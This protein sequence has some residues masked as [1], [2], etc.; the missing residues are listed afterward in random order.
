L[1]EIRNPNLQT[2]GTPGGSGGG[3]DMR[4]TMAFFILMLAVLFGYQYFFKPK[5]AP[6]TPAAQTQALAQSQS[7]SPQ[8]GAPGP[9]ELTPVPASAQSSAGATPTVAATSET[10]T[11]VENELYKIVFT[12]RGAQV[13]S[14]ILKKY[15]DSYGKPLDM[16]QP[17]TAAR[18][19][20]PL[21]LFTY[22]PA[23]T[24]Q[25]NQA[26]YQPSATGVLLAPNSL[27]FHYAA[28]G[29][30]VV[31]TFRF[32]SSYVLTV[33]SEVKRN[34]V[35]V[36][37]LVRWPAGLGDM[38]EFVPGKSRS[39]AILTVSQF[40]WSID[41]KSD[42]TV[43]AKVSGNATVDQPYQY[44]GI[45]DLYF[46]AAFMPD[47]PASASLVTIHNTIDLPG[48]L[49]DPN[50]QKKPAHVIGLAM[51]D[52]GGYS[53]LRFYVGPK[54]MDVLST[55]HA[56]GADGKTDGP[57][58]EPLIHYG[59][60][61]I[62][63][64]PLYIALRFNHGLLG[65]GINNWGWSIIIFTAA[66]NLI[67]LPTRFI[68]MKS[69]VKMMRIQPKVDAIRKKYAH[70]KMN[71][72][73]R[74]EMN[75]EI[76]ALHQAEGINMVGGCLPLLV[77][78]PLF[79]AYFEV[80]SNVIELR[81]AHWFWLTDLSLPDPLHILPVLIILSMFLTQFITPSPGMDPAQR[82]MMA[83]MMPVFFG[84]MLWH[85]AS[86]LA[87]YWGTSNLI[88]LAMQLGINQS[89]MGKEMHAIAAKRAAKKTG[90]GGNNQ[91]T[92]QA[93]R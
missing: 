34:G 4:S 87:L 68:M 77:Q 73:K 33:E 41:G 12:N 55:I 90:N 47:S 37:A 58:L 65:S 39:G 7:P 82:R 24:S 56:I 71:D 17:Q 89:P 48:D 74:A 25:L 76:M 70:L 15:Q 50:S 53:R 3:G 84:F 69:S 20:Y 67:M 72:P 16:V 8:A 54:Q 66:F 6:T 49:S 86:G 51:G 31:K 35:P 1:P 26:M 63:A 57:S 42:Q 61:G 59:W 36:R 60:L 5:T 2:P 11:T 91:R 19:G 13:K 27:A 78:M 92:I 32:D 64:K 88:N 23:L 38:E 52:Q 85:Y 80:L 79:I 10:E 44:A 46:A 21:S 9:A 28:S 14:W 18:F 45:S 40:A 81:Q 29:L 62:V 43:A 22:E 93:R 83:F 75:T 30:D